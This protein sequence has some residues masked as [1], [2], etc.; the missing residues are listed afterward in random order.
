[1]KVLIFLL[2]VILYLGQ[3]LFAVEQIDIPVYKFQ[4]DDNRNVV[5]EQTLNLMWQDDES[6]AK[7]TKNW[8]EATEYCSQ[9]TYLEFH[10]WRLPNLDEL[11]PLIDEMRSSPPAINKQFKNVFQAQYWTNSTLTR[12][13]Y[14]SIKGDEYGLGRSMDALNESISGHKNMEIKN[15][16]GIGFQSGQMYPYDKS[17]NFHIRCVRNNQ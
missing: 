13:E 3:S 4:R 16:W 17:E 9:L 11:M 1:M 6:V 5:I 10:N 15:A 14:L 8:E 2:S 12:D 7:V